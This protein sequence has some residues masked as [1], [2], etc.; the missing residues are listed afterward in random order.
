MANERPAKCTETITKPRRKSI[1]SQIPRCAVSATRD[2]AFATIIIYMAILPAHHAPLSHHFRTTSETCELKILPTRPDLSLTVVDILCGHSLLC[3]ILLRMLTVRVDDMRYLSF[4]TLLVSEPLLHNDLDPISHVELV[5]GHTPHLNSMIPL[6]F[7]AL[8]KLLQRR[9]ANE[10]VRECPG[11][12]AACH[13]TW[14]LFP[15]FS[16]G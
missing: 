7:P 10:G 5:D 11:A 13:L 14:P 15:L 3:N 8:S 4:S 6:T 16:G 9:R 12:R 1:L 2:V